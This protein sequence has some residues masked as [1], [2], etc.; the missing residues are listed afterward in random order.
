MNTPKSVDEV[1]S[2]AGGLFE[3]S[4]ADSFSSWAHA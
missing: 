2:P 1:L 3:K 4:W